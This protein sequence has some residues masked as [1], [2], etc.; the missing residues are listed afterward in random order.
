[1]VY[2]YEQEL[3]MP[4]GTRRLPDFTVHRSGRP[5]VYWEHLGMLDRP[6]YAADWRAK[7]Q[8]YAAHGILPW[9]E[10]GGV[11]GTLVWSTENHASAGIDS[12]AIDA[13][14]RD[15]LVNADASGEPL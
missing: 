14:A 5:P 12:Q 15:L 4:D 2:A 3:T 10:G 6:G 8:W 11:D 9:T 1:V 13:L 7:Q